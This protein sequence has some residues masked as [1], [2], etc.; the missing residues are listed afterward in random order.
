MVVCGEMLTKM[1]EPL[2]SLPSSDSLFPPGQNA[3]DGDGSAS[4]TSL[5]P[6][7]PDLYVEISRYFFQSF[8]F[9]ENLHHLA[10][11]YLF[12][13]F[14]STILESWKSLVHGFDIYKRIKAIGE[15]GQ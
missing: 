11:R 2:V 4:A 13:K 12:E 3:A 5:S 15:N 1:V 10:I 7:P 6:L 8:I 14:L 9:I